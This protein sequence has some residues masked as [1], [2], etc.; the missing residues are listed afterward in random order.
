MGPRKAGKTR[1][2]TEVQARRSWLGP[3]ELQQ[4]GYTFAIKRGG[5]PVARL[6]RIPTTI[7]R[8]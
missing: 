8:G 6:E 7:S 2:L 4:K 1:Y 5:K 3:I